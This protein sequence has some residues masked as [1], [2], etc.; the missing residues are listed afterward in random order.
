MKVAIIGGGPIG[1]YAGYL[2]AKAGNQVEIYENHSQIGAPIQCTGILTSD[3]DQFN[4]PLDSFLV[5]TIENIEVYSPN[6]KVAIKQKDYIVCRT[7]FD[8]FFGDLA[9]KAGA[10]IFLN[11]SFQGKEG[12]ELVIKD[13][14]NG[15]EKRILPE[16]VI[17]ADGPLSPTTKAYGFYHPRDNYYGVQA[18]V[19]GHFNPNTIQTFFGNQVCPG[20]FAWITPESP[21]V[22]RVGLA[23]KKDSK[24][25]FDEFMEEHGFIAKEM[26][27]GV[28]PVYQPQQELQKDNC[29]L[30]GDASTYVKATTLGGIVPAMQQVQVLVDCLLKGKN[31]RD[32]IAPVR[33]K[34]WLHLKIHRMMEKF[35]DQDWDQLVEYVGNSGVTQVLERHTRDSPWP[36]VWKAIWREPRFLRFVKYL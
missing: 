6:S 25:Y 11:H 16:V 36:I 13:S 30:V 12:D 35:T 32:E 2:L 23:C 10:Q 14:V 1:C 3:F 19:E 17:A 15:V 7:K 26:Q 18:V 22:A 5:N 33:R 24:K 27:A 28:I 8:S 34:M 4:F 9:S 31:Y 21:T 29:Y 20:L